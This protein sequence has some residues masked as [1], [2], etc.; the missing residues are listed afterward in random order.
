MS[1]DYQIVKYPGAAPGAD[2]NTYNLFDSTAFRS[3]AKSTLR[4]SNFVRY[5]LALKNA[6]VGTLKAYASMDAGAT[7][8]EFY[9][10]AVPVSTTQRMN[11]ITIPLEPHVDVKIDWVNGGAAQTTWYV[12]QA[13]D[14]GQ[15]LV[16]TV[17]LDAA[18]D[19]DPGM[20]EIVTSP[21]LPTSLGQKVKAGSLAVVLPSDQLG[22]QAKAAAL[23]IQF[24]T[25]IVGQL[26][27]AF[28]ISTVAAS[29]STERK[30]ASLRGCVR[31][32]ELPISV[33]TASKT[34][35]VPAAWLGKHV[36]IQADG[37]DV[38]YQISLT[39]TA[40]V[41][42]L[43]A[44]ATETGGPPIALTAAASGNGC[45]KIPSGTFV[46][47]PFPASATTFALIGSAACCAR[48]FI[49]ET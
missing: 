29:D 22:P 9:E 37:G 42:D 48:T 10:L 32:E 46:D 15:A 16:R 38:Y 17:F 19:T 28:S 14:N 3:G 44:R 34:F 27:S 23:A 6:A 41:A 21:Q 43:T 24:A 25:D 33:T 8:L 2:S 36:R 1:D 40:A 12:G 13:L 39:G 5:V 30:A 18:G 35:T 49:A 20:A 31:G 7:W 47:I 45:A 4:F 26:T 11:Q